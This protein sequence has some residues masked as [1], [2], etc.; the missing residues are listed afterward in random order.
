ME[1][2]QVLATVEEELIEFGPHLFNVGRYLS[3]DQGKIVISDEAPEELKEIYN[4]GKSYFDRMYLRYLYLYNKY[5]SRVITPRKT[6]EELMA[7]CTTHFQTEYI[8]IIK[9]PYLLTGHVRNLIGIYPDAKEEELE[10]IGYYIS[11]KGEKLQKEEHDSTIVFEIR[12]DF[13][14]TWNQSIL[15]KLAYQRGID[16]E[17]LDTF[18]PRAWSYLIECDSYFTDPE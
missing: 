7:Y 9:D 13:F 3:I 2:E 18:N 12:H 4:R 17:Y 6:I 15:R 10:F 5:R 16:A 11:R 14:G 8:G 1:K